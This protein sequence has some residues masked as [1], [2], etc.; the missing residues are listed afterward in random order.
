MNLTEQKKKLQTHK[1]IEKDLLY[2]KMRYTRCFYSVE[3]Y[4]KLLQCSVFFF[5]KLQSYIVRMITVH[6]CHKQISKQLIK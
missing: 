3:A 4:Y 2:H 1:I 5:D 6:F